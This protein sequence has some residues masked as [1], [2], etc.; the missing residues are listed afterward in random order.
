MSRRRRKRITIGD[1]IVAL[2][3]AAVLAWAFIPSARAW[4]DAAWKR[5]SAQWAPGASSSIDSLPETQAAAELKALPVRDSVN[6]GAPEYSRAAFGQAWAD[7]DHNGCDT[8]ND[9]LA[10]DLARPTFKA[11][12]RDCVVLTGTLAEPYTGSVIEFQRGQDT[13]AL[14]Q[15]DHVVALA[16]AWRSGAWQWDAAA[17]QKFAN[18]QS[19]L[20]AV[21]GRANEDKSSA[22]ADEWLPPN[23]DFRCD[24][25]KTQISV[26]TT[27]GLSVTAAERDAMAEVLRAC[28]D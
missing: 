12:T 4:A 8:R 20:L 3:V 11:G 5:A 19:N 16:D 25:V 22:S 13:S 18:D 27:W 14:V 7:E 9:V 2:L 23:E 21:D 15:I 17:R 6:G 24:Y 28:P 26:K 1:W 10:R